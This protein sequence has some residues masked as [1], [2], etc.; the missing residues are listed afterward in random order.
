MPEIADSVD[1]YKYQISKLKYVGGI[2][3]HFWS[4]FKKKYFFPVYLKKL[5]KKY[6]ILYTFQYDQIPYWSKEKHIIVDLDDPVFSDEEIR[7]LKYPNVKSLIVSTDY[8]K[9]KFQS[10]GV[11][12][13]ITVIYQGVHDI[14]DVKSEL[15]KNDKI[16]LG[17]M[18]PTLS[19]T[20]DN[21]DKYRNG[22]DNLDLLF[23]ALDKL[24]ESDKSKIIVSLIGNASS[25][26]HDMAKS[27]PYIK[28]EGLVASDRVMD[29]V[30]N[31][32]I[33]LY[34]RTYILPPGRSSV[35][36]V[37]Y[38]ILSKPVVATNLNETM[39]VNQAS[40]G[41]V[42]ENADVF[43]KALTNLINDKN[44]RDV[45]GKN[46]RKFAKDNFL[47][48]DTIIKYKSFFSDYLTKYN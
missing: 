27:R 36:I 39:V 16:V 29:L 28:L 45:L 41:L 19:T 43:S 18:A 37:Q 25:T 38:M 4:F 32:D 15:I 42:C 22:V 34:P 12:I 23:E 21:P 31:F 7:M 24:D 46:G 35:K 9:D 5:A 6:D 10:L 30:S 2:H 3:Y 44:Q 20:A 48:K 47:F 1:V 17:Y 33:G 13:P 26:V 14:S 8:V 40:S 11:D